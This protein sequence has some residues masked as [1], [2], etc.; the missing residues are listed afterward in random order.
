MRCT[1]VVC[2]AA[3][4]VSVVKDWTATAVAP[5][6][7]HVVTKTC[8]TTNNARITPTLNMVCPTPD[9]TVTERLRPFRVLSG[10]LWVDPVEG[11][12]PLWVGPV[13]LPGLRLCAAP[14]VVSVAGV[15]P[16]AEPAPAG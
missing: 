3:E 16:V 12:G 13:E 15:A 9:I 8:H 4:A 5:W 11:F 6:T 7:C 1:S 2:V 14:E 10:P